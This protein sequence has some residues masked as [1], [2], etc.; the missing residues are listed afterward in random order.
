MTEYHVCPACGRPESPWISVKDRLPAYGQMVICWD[1]ITFWKGCFQKGRANGPVK[2]D[3][4]RIL[5]GSM[6]KYYVTEPERITHWR[7][8]KGP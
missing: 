4:W 8:I 7:E 3:T 5:T 6:N 2:K 1:G